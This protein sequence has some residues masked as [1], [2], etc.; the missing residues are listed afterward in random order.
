MIGSL[1]QRGDIP[2]A[3]LVEQVLETV[4][5]L[6]DL[7][8][9]RVLDHA[10][11]AEMNEI[12]AALTPL[13]DATLDEQAHALARVE[14]MRRIMIT[15]N[16][17][18]CQLIAR[19]LLEQLVPNLEKLHGFAEFDRNTHRNLVVEL[20]EALRTRNRQEVARVFA[21]LGQINLNTI[22]AALEGRQS[23]QHPGA[24]LRGFSP[25]KLLLPIVVVLVAIVAGVGII[26][27]SE[28]IKPATP[29]PI[30]PSV[31]VVT[32]IPE[33]VQLEVT[34]QGTVLPNTE[35]ELI[36]EVSG[37][38]VWVAES[39]REGGF[40]EAGSVLLR[41][42]PKDMRASVKRAQAAVERSSAELEL[43]SFEH[44]R[45]TKLVADNL[46]SVS[47]LEAAL[48]S[49]RV[50]QAAFEDAE[51]ALTQ[52]ETDLGRTEIRAPFTGLVRKKNVDVG[53]FANRGSLLATLYANDLVEVRL[54]IADRQ[55]AYLNLPLGHW[56]T[57]PEARQPAVT[58]SA[59]YAGRNLEWEGEVGAD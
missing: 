9:S 13:K 4:H 14:L 41:L 18:I 43:A 8:V 48:R 36:A 31:R 29:E 56:G 30:P 3:Q 52:A 55:L 51:V 39:L 40:F 27:T 44:E 2:E 28:S 54:P 20:D 19:T 17:L 33:S 6:V 42:D 47:Q 57:L 58:L 15:S 24:A 45:L 35:S 59:N 7:A 5:S 25:M 10:T 16:H 11:E 12:R 23:R 21:A 53:Q 22:L 46:V 37:R 32:V 38:V 49:R 26:A 34:S 1:L 50:A